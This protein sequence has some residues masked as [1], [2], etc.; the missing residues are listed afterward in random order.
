MPPTQRPLRL[1]AA[2]LSRTR[3]EVT[4]RSNWA[5]DS[6]TF[7]VS[8]PIILARAGDGEGDLGQAWVGFAV[9]G[10][11]VGE[12]HDPLHLTTPFARQEGAGPQRGPGSMAGSHEPLNRICRARPDPVQQ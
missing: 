10:E 7:S 1:E 11:P 12:H 8:R 5:N 4:S 3:S 6:S 9:P 2:I